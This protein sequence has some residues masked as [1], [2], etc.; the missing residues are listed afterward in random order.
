VVTG[1]DK[2]AREVV[3]KGKEGGGSKFDRWLTSKITLLGRV[4]SN[5]LKPENKNSIDCILNSNRKTERK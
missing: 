2:G 4:P 1:G 5:L 3:S